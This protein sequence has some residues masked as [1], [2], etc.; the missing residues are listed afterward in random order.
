MIHYS[1]ESF[2]EREDG[3]SPRITSIALRNL[4]T[5]QTSSYSIH[6]IAER[7]GIAAADIGNNYDDLERKMLDL[8]FEHVGSHKGA[9]YM[10]WNM[11]D[12]NYGFAAIAHRYAVLGG[13]PRNIDDVKKF[14]LSRLLID[15]YGV[16]YIG[17]P[18]LE[19]LLDEN[20]IKPRD[21]LSGKDEAA[22]FENGN[23][24]GLHQSTLRKVDVLANISERAKNR[25]LRTKATWW[26]MHGGRLRT[27]VNWIVEHKGLA[28]LITLI[29][30]ALGIY[31]LL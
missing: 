4:K 22:A 18:R 15:I 24:V 31:S 17:H 23:Y 14:D 21:F 19:N 6:Q 20:S 5:A 1:C 16:S 28:F 8:Y 2:Y 10:H 25:Q 11:R 30:L 27:G 12:A 26:D 9:N 29:S 3:S 7:S 13:E